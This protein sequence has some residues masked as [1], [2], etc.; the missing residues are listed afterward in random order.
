MTASDYSDQFTETIRNGRDNGNGAEPP[1]RELGPNDPPTDYV[2]PDEALIPPRGWLYAGHYMRGIIS[3]TFSPGGFGKS[4][5]DDKDEINRRIA[6]HCRLHEIKFAELAGRLFVDDRMSFPFSIAEAPRPG[7][8]KFHHDQLVRFEAGV[9]SKKVDAIILDPLVSFH[10][11]AENDNSAIDAIVKRLG[12]IAHNAKCGIE[13]C[14]HVRKLMAGQ[15]ALSVDDARGASAL[16]NACRSARIINRMTIQEAAQAHIDPEQ[17]R[18]YL[19]IDNGKANMRPASTAFW[20]H[21]V[22]VEL[23]NGDHVQALAPWK[24]PDLFAGVTLADTDW[25]RQIVRQKPY[26]CDRQ[27]KDWL[28]YE[29]ARRLNLNVLDKPDCIRINKIIAAW[30][31]NK[32][33]EKDRRLD[34]DTRHKRWFYVAKKTDDDN[35][36]PFP[37]F[38]INDE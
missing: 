32:V 25:I 8:I 33:F 4:G 28:G 14:H 18:A 3:A 7:K 9:A 30:L 1:P 13:T 16:V 19:R 10:S 6:A 17:R 22:D 2:P 11:L 37:T 5:E 21:L 20:L 34:P 31:A 27:G 23:L 29:I 38:D 35:V 24:F 36:I 26:H 12:V 15:T